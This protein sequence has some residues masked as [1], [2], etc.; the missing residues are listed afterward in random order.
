M[1]KTSQLPHLQTS[2]LPVEKLKKT[3]C[4]SMMLLRSLK[5]L[6]V[7]KTTKEP[8]WSRCQTPH[9]AQCVG[10]NLHPERLWCWWF[11][12]AKWW[13]NQAIWKI[14]SSQWESSPNRGEN[15]TCLKPPPSMDTD[16]SFPKI[17]GRFRIG[18]GTHLDVIA[19]HKKQSEKIIAEE[20]IRKE[21]IVIYI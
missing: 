7:K 11:L 3:Q 10:H 6:P 19:T 4:P 14:W 9:V 21:P 8:R 12:C 13:L 17:V 5:P 16:K 2:Q 20:K 15:K 18:A 1:H